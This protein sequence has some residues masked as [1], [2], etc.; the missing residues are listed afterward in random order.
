MAIETPAF[1]GKNYELID[2]G[3]F[4]KLEQFG[5]FVVRR[6]EPQAVWQ[7]SLSEE[8]WASKANAYFKKEKGSNERGVWEVKKGV[9]D[10]WFMPYQSETLDLNFKISLSSFKHVGIF[11]EQASNWEFLAKNIPLLKTPKP[12][13]LNLFAYTGGASLACKQVGADVTH[14]DS[15][16]PVLS[17]ARENMEVSKLDNIRWMAEDALKFVKREARRGNFYQG[18]LLDPPAYGRGPEGEKW[19]LEEQIDDMLRSVKEILDPKEHI[20]LTNVYSLGF[21]TLVVENLM[22]GIFNVPE[23]AESGEIYLN[24]EYDKKLPLGVFYRYLYQS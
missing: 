7:K 2:S 3:G 4:E 21:S 13:I 17:W 6:P 5:A 18:I 1:W 20:L 9:P 24:D 11:P 10:K 23:K 22:K 14:V 12:K 8:F 16:K 15:V 19:V